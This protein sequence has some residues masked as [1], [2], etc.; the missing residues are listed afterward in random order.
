[1]GAWGVIGCGAVAIAVAVSFRAWM[2]MD[3]TR[4]NKII[5][6]ILMSILTIV[7][8]TYSFLK[9]PQKSAFVLPMAPFIIIIFSILLSRKMMWAFA[10]AMV[11]SCFFLG[12]NLDDPLRGSKATPL[13][14]RTQI[15]NTPVTVDMLSGMV[16]ADDTKRKQKIGYA[17]SVVKTLQTV[18]TKTLIIAGW[19]QNELN[20]FSLENKNPLVTYTY[21]S[22]E[23]ELSE[24]KNK[25]Y[26]IFFL[27]EQDFY[28]D[29][30][31]KGAFTNVLAKPF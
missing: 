24:F 31:F 5:P 4:K 13:A 6:A 27:P 7:L 29:L 20:Y 12:I 11:F 19:W 21:Y 14:F 3:I 10:S 9:I 16:V 15:G 30:R 17:Q 25:G 2:K 8:Y 1:I 26:Q 22:D 23:K 18:N 28:N